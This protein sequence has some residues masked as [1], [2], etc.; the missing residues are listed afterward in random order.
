MMRSALFYALFRRARSLYNL[1]ET[2]SGSV[3]I[4]PLFCRIF[5]HPS[6]AVEKKEQPHSLHNCFFRLLLHPFYAMTNGLSFGAIALS[7]LPATNNQTKKQDMS[8][9]Q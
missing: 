3:K 7:I 9:I 8:L 1:R 4:K 2:G 6:L 5:T